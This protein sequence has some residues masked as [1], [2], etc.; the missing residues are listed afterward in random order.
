M[1]SPPAFTASRSTSPATFCGPCHRPTTRTS[2]LDL[3][4]QR[5][6]LLPGP[7]APH[8]AATAY[9]ELVCL[10]AG[11]EAER[12]VASGVS[13]GAG[14]D[15]H[16]LR[17]RP[18][19]R[20]RRAYGLGVV[21]PG[22]SRRRARLA[23]RRTRRDCVRP[24]R[25]S[26]GPGCRAPTS[27]RPPDGCGH[28]PRLPPPPSASSTP[29]CASATSTARPLPPCSP[30]SCRWGWQPRTCPMRPPYRRTGRHHDPHPPPSARPH[31]WRAPS[32]ATSRH[33]SSS[34]PGGMTP[35]EPRPAMAS[36][37]VSRWSPPVRSRRRS[38]RPR[39]SATAG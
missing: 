29:S 30:T 37:Q 14:A 36:R 8:T 20:P 6:R 13:S 19:D 1:P 31:P 34:R 25:P 35:S 22:A 7:D 33:G 2:R 28:P 18:S 32:T 17:L 3:P 23:S 21:S 15:G 38:A 4:P 9:A 26:H 39:G 11:R 10:L 27:R 5:G 16:C 12:L 24:G